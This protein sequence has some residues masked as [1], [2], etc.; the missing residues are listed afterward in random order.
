MAKILQVVC[1][2]IHQGL[3]IIWGGGGASDDFLESSSLDLSING[4]R[5]KH[6]ENCSKKASLAWI[7]SSVVIVR[8]G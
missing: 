6:M 7:S 1:A 2:V 8:F 4:F 5:V 3:A